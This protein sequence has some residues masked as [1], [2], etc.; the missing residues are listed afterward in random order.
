MCRNWL[1]VYCYARDRQKDILRA[2]AETKRVGRLS[3]SN[4]HRLRWLLRDLIC[5]APG[6]RVGR[7]ARPGTD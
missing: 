6:A 2:V 5:F 3:G 1:E 7:L 4:H